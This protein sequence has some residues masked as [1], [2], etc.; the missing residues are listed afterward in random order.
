[1]SETRTERC[2]CICSVLAKDVWE[3]SVLE[4]RFQ[5]VNHDGDQGVKDSTGRLTAQLVTSSGLHA[6][7]Q[8]ISAERRANSRVVP[9]TRDARMANGAISTFL[10]AKDPGFDLDVHLPKLAVVKDIGGCRLET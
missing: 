5:R 6:G 4:I 1:V 8:R 10:G 2:G 7:R 9:L 3:H